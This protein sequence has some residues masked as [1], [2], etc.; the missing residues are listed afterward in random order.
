MSLLRE[1]LSNPDIHKRI[2]ENLNTKMATANGL[3][4]ADD[5]VHRRKASQ[6]G[7]ILTTALKLASESENYGEEAEQVKAQL[8][9]ENVEFNDLGIMLRVVLK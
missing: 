5:M 6:T 7:K 1:H 2:L 3:L 8:E 4:N 9:A